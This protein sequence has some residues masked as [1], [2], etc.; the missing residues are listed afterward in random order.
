VREANDIFHG[1]KQTNDATLDSRLMVSVSDIAVRKAN[2]LVLGDTSTGV[3]VDEFLSKCITYM[4]NGGP[5]EGNEDPAPARRR[6]NNTRQES[7]DESEDDAVGEPLDWE[8]LGRHACVPYNSRPP[9]PSFLLGPLSVQKKQRTQTQRRARQTRE[10]GREAR[11]ENLSSNDLSLSNEND[12]KAVC[13]RLH[14]D[15]LAHCERGE[16][17]LERAGIASRDQLRSDKALSIMRKKRISVTGGPSLLEYALNPKD[18]GQTVENL[19]RISFL[20]KEGTFGIE[21]D[22]DGLPT[23]CK[24]DHKKNPVVSCHTD[25]ASQVPQNPGL[26]KTNAKTTSA[27]TKPFSRSTIPLGICWWKRMGIANP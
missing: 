5:I 17:A 2:Q 11:P 22:D 7:D 1:V 21:P 23:I 16:D 12:L 19:F 14:D 15:L 25:S 10:T 9:V 24:S 13:K 4:R 20:I 18:F 8:M 6:R 26:W 27:S 3:D